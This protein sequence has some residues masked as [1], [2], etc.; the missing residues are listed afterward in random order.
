MVTACPLSELEQ[1][2]P[3]PSTW[4]VDCGIEIRNGGSCTSA[5][6]A[7]VGRAASQRRE[8]GKCVSEVLTDDCSMYI[9]LS[10]LSTW[11]SR[12]STDPVSNIQASARYGLIPV[13]PIPYLAMTQTRRSKSDCPSFNV[14]RSKVTALAL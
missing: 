10:A 7:Q 11:T 2:N 4:N 5:P 6:C 9:A 12:L 13:N 1:N 8:S 14:C 3:S